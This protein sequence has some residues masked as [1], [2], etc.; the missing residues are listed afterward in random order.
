M[1]VANKTSHKEKVEDKEHYF[2]SKS[3]KEESQKKAN[4]KGKEQILLIY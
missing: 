2:F 3:S 4:E 1:D